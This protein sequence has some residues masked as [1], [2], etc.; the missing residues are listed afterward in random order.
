MPIPISDIDVWVFDLDNTLYNPRRS[1]LMPQM[2]LRMQEF[3][4]GEF[5]VDETE[6]DRRRQ[7]YFERYGTT[8]RGLMEHHG[9]S[10]ERFLPY[11][12]QLDLTGIAHDVELDRGLALLPGRKIVYTNATAAHAAAVLERLGLVDHFEGIFDIAD[13]DYMPKPHEPSYD[14]FVKRFGFRPERAAMFEDTAKNLKPA[15]LLGM[16]TVWMRNDRP[17]AQPEP[18]AAHIHHVADELAEFIH[19]VVGGAEAKAS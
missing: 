19:E 3:I 5:G 18:E 13:A 4:M 12:H 6:A 15:H 7:F 10:P 9:M 1:D 14:V 17:A 2:H 16:R 11:C 8:L